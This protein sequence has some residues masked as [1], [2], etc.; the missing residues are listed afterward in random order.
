MEDQELDF[1]KAYLE[2][3]QR[4]IYSNMGLEPV[5]AESYFS[6]DEQFIL[7]FYKE[8]GPKNDQSF[9]EFK[10]RLF[11]EQ[12]ELQELTPT[13]F[14]DPNWYGLVHGMALKIEQV[15]KSLGY[16]FK[17]KPLFGTIPTGR[18]NGMALKIPNSSYCAILIEDGLFGFANLMC[19]AVARVFPFIK[20]DNGMMTFS[21]DEAAWKSELNSSDVIKDR[22]F[23]AL[24]SYLVGGHPHMAEPYLPERNY[25]SFTSLL[26]DSMELF[27]LCHEYGHIISGH[28]DSDGKKS[29]IAG[30]EDEEVFLSWSEEIEADVRGLELFLN[31]RANDGY[32]LALSFMGADLFFGCIE[33]I[34]KSVAILKNGTDET[35][36]SATHPPVSFR[37]EALRKALRR[38]FTEEQLE[39]VFNLSDTAYSIVGA[40]W[41][42]SEERLIRAHNNGVHPSPGWL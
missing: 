39:G 18:V 29:M 12:R 42:G 6:F 11:E 41:K 21:T 19:K 10:E 16:E 28:L 33:A 35:S 36:L 2:N 5:K 26:R 8:L 23:D 25:D 3:L 22:F 32:D 15:V 7:N 37:R 9:E 17:S 34:E 40:L 30:V 4:K 24:F 13:K 14:E 27:I 31:V 20:T 1:A 38:S